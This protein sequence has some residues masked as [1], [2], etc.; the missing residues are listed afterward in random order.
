MIAPRFLPV[1]IAPQPPTEWNRTA[2]GLVR[3]QRRRIVRLHFVGMIDAEDDEA[4]R[5]PDARLPSFRARLPMAILVGANRVLGPEVARAEP[6]DA[7]Q[8]AAASAPA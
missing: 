7:G 1:V 4:S 5:R 3:Q 6:V 2:I 8:R